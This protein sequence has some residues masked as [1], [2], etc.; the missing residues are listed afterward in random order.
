MANLVVALIA[1][2]SFLGVVVALLQSSLIPMANVSG[3][4]KQM[5]SISAQAVRTELEEVDLQVLA[6]GSE[7]R[8]SAANAGNASLR[9]FSTWDVIV[10]YRASST[11][12]DFQVRRLSYTAGS[13]G[14]NEWTVSGIYR[15]AVLGTAELFD[16]GVLDPG[17]QVT[18]RM[19]VSPASATSTAGQVVLAARN[20][21][22]L[23]SQF[24]R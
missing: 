24:V 15:D 19:R 5:R 16:P 10:N 7:I 18:L 21:V 9:D 8:L 17:E 3:S 12:T 1:L 6:G 22:T 23:S 11:S 13:P 20:G 14:D 4:W 2:G